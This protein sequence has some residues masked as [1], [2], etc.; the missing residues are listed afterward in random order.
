ML[1]A[2][3]YSAH[4]HELWSRRAE[5]V[6]EICSGPDVTT[7]GYH[8]SHTVVLCKPVILFPNVSTWRRSSRLLRHYPCD[9]RLFRESVLVYMH[10]V[11]KRKR[12]DWRTIATDGTTGKRKRE[13]KGR[14]VREQFADRFVPGQQGQASLAQKKRSWCQV[15]FGL[16]RT[17]SS[18]GGAS[19]DD[20]H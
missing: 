12:C 4:G 1:P 17:E 9:R 14:N 20:P 11:W 15:Q 13:K 6:P 10:T 8:V 3:L 16:Y 2:G 19:S 7:F 18:V 5:N